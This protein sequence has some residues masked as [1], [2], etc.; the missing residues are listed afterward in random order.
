[1]MNEMM[2]SF[3]LNF[4]VNLLNDC[5][6]TFTNDEKRI[7]V[8]AALKRRTLIC[9]ADEVRYKWKHG[10]LSQHVPG[11]RIALTMREA[12]PTFKEGGEL[13]EKFGKELIRLS[14]VR[15]AF[16]NELT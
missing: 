3:Q 9:M 6:M 7:V 12:S 14:N 1:M 4:S 8:Y 10:V 5:V 2:N 11:R 13:Y 16:S 15:I